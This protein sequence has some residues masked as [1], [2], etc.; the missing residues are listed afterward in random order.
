MY[1]NQR[2]EKISHEQISAFSTFEK[3]HSELRQEAVQHLTTLARDSSDPGWAAHRT[4]R[5]FGGFLYT[6]TLRR[7]RVGTG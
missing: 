1:L 3:K 5:L 4:V 2:V 7:R 6:D